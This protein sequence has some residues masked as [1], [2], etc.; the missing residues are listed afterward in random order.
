M[1]DPTNPSTSKTR[2]TQRT[3]SGRGRRAAAEPADAGEGSSI[4]SVSRALEV[5]GWLADSPDGLSFP[6][7]RDLLGTNQGACF[8]VLSTLEEAGY[9]F[10]HEYS[11]RYLLT[12]KVANLALRKLH[13]A[14]LLDQATFAL[15]ALANSTGESVALAVV[16]ASKLT[17]VLSIAGQKTRDYS[18]Q[19][20]PTRSMRVA[21]HA[22]A[23]GKAWMAALAPKRAREL[24]KEQ[25]MPKFTER[26]LTSEKA[27]FA[28]LARVREFGY[29]MSYE[30]SE[31]GICGVAAPVTVSQ[32]DGEQECVAVVSLF[33]PA[34]RMSRAELEQYAP[35]VVASG[36]KLAS[37]WPLRPLGEL[38]SASHSLRQMA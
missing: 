6:Q 25:G 2:A 3:A 12:Y 4:V 35:S 5:I 9:V 23:T 21:L 1:S 28:E 11:G 16:E 8:K 34:A 30:E 26:T 19:I 37:N 27:L 7:L 31:P 20:E 24:L 36:K 17:F 22:H 32:L 29:A 13:H 33:A 38:S 18:L 15:R 14:R 10:R